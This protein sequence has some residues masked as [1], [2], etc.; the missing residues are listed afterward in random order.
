MQERIR[1]L[2]DDNKRLTNAMFV[3][4]GLRAPYDVPMQPLPKPQGRKT[5]E[6]VRAE[7]EAK[8]ANAE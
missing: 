4:G 7:L 1:T 5:W 8:E 2:E 3:Q 6:E